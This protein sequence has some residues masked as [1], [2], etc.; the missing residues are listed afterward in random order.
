MS[1]KQ[2]AP[3]DNESPAGKTI[4]ITGASDGIGAVSA[5]ELAKQ[6]ANVVVI[7]RSPQKTAAVAADCGSE[8]LTADF[9][10]LAQVRRLAG[11]LIE[12]LE[13]IDVL[14]NNAG[15]MFRHGNKT[16][17]GHEPNFQ[18]NH[19]APFLLTNLLK[20]KLTAA[21]APR[22]IVTSSLGNNV[23][24][25]RLD[26]LDYERR[27]TTDTIAYGSSKLQNIL[28]AREL[29]RRWATDD[30]TA[31]A[32]HPGVVSSQFGRD[33]WSAGLIYRT[34]LKRVLM[35]TPEKGATPIVDL[36]TRAGREAINGEFFNRHKPS[37][38]TNRQAGDAGLASGLWEQSELLT[39]LTTTGVAN[40]ALATDE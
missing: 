18:I 9:A 21:P 35:I 22:V 24:H 11:E 6:G 7:G 13:Q 34:P 23:G 26:D 16:A 30:V 10:E 40:T 2:S 3:R 37:G 15:G 12:R 20:Q 4:V 39:G 27:R 5:R 36:A 1:S 14:V 29:A 31:T 38:L 17:D 33:S 32:F 19:L 8:P 25:V 28:F